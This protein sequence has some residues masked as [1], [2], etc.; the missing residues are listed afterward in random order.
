MI[1]PCRHAVTR[2]DVLVQKYVEQLRLPAGCSEG[3]IGVHTP[4]A[5]SVQCI[6]VR[7]YSR[8]ETGNGVLVEDGGR[9]G[10]WALQGHYTA[11]GQRWTRM[12]VG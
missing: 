4:L 3:A 12:P 1:W 6:Q 8:E 2:E 7:L 10:G 11:C 9:V 5:I